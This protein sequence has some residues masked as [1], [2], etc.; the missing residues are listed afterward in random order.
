MLLPAW[1]LTA[2]ALAPLTLLAQSEFNGNW[3]L[4]PQNGASH[5][6]WLEV[7]ADAGGRADGSFYGAT[8]GRLARILDG[9][10]ERGVL[11]FRVER[12]FDSPPNPHWTRARVEARV[13]KRRL[14]GL[15]IEGGSKIPLRGWP[16]LD[17]PDKDD[18]A[19]HDGP[20]V[21]LLGRDN[22]SAW[23]VESLRTGRGWTFES[24][25]LA[26]TGHSDNLVSRERFR[27]LALHVEFRLAQTVNSGI[28]LR[29]RYEVQLLGDYGDSPDVHG[30]GAI[31][32]RIRPSVNASRPGSDWQTLD[33]RLVGREVTVVLND[34][35]II[36]R[37]RID[38]PC[39]LTLDGYE[40]QPGPIVLQGDH[41]P[42]QFR[43]LR[44][45]TLVK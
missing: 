6:F 38:G 37:R 27:N 18:G 28:S 33:A 12:Y 44:V 29:G 17:L 25:I 40:D 5:V 1:I 35:K 7:H 43:N 21:Q 10:F 15:L 20:A 39:G 8:G 23:H 26:A 32:S 41:G 9:R 42:V 4:E 14:D 45:V 19:W 3:V 34:V 31:Y 11:T 30:N 2:A 24:G 22:L 16:S 13:K 36:D